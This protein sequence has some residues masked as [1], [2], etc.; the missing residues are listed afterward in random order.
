[1]E[2]DWTA[3]AICYML[4]GWLLFEYAWHGM[5]MYR[6]W[7]EKRDNAYPAYSRP[8][9]QKWSRWRMMPGAL[10]LLPARFVMMHLLVIL[11]AIILR[12]AL[13]GQDMSKPF[14]RCRRVVTKFILR[15]FSKLLLLTIGAWVSVRHVDMDYS[16]WLGPDY[17]EQYKPIK[18][19]S[20]VVMNHTTV[21]DV[22]CLTS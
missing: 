4:F 3:F 18:K 8:D 22:L 9:V 10:I 15:L 6:A 7:D 17:K 19:V 21:F 13:I 1:M 11:I 16:E 2:F 12:I 14:S 5:S 20:T